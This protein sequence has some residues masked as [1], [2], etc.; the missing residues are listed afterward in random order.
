MKR[1]QERSLSN[2][3]NNRTLDERRIT[4]KKLSLPRIDKNPQI[5]GTIDHELMDEKSAKKGRLYEY[6]NKNS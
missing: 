6:E 3:R 2:T 1:N 4:L 5:F